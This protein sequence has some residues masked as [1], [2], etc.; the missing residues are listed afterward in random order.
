[1]D[2]SVGGGSAPSGWR[3]GDVHPG[4]QPP[5]PPEAGEVA[6]QQQQRR[7][8]RGDPSRDGLSGDG[9]R[10]ARDAAD[11]G[12][13][14]RSAEDRLR[15]FYS[16][17]PAVLFRIYPERVRISTRFSH[18]KALKRPDSQ[19]RRCR[20]SRP[21]RAKDPRRTLVW[22]PLLVPAR[23]FYTTFHTRLLQEILSYFQRETLGRLDSRPGRWH[24]SLFARDPSTL[25]TT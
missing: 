14:D 6:H 25:C 8:Q 15:E 4:R 19:E 16:T 24:K 3:A 1:M 13:H 9:L 21:A 7:K 17:P 5:V 10:H 22:C 18:Q 11:S 23:C 2:T 20:N 12:R